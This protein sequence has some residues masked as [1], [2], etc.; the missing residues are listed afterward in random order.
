MLNH[1]LTA[2][3]IALIVAIILWFFVMNDQNPAIE[4][5][6]TVP[7]EVHNV[8]E[9]YTVRYDVDS[10]KL[11][12]KG[13]RSLF[14]AASD[15]E[16]RAFIDLSGLEE[17]KHAV[18]VQT[19]L[20]QGFELAAISTESV[21][22]EVD[23][24]IERDIRVDMAFSGTP[25]SGVTV[26]RATPERENVTVEGPRSI[27][28]AISRVV[29][30]VNLSGIDNDFTT[31]VQLIAV[32]IDGKEVGG[33]KVKPDVVKVSTS[34]VKGLYKKEVDLRP[35]LG[36]DLPAGLEI[37]SVKLDPPKVEIYGDQRL[38]DKIDSIYTEKIGLS[39]IASSAKRQVKLN[40][41]LGI[42]TTSTIVNV[43]LEY[44]AKSAE[45][46][47]AAENGEDKP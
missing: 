14:A 46:K 43:Q 3:I 44:R 35:S 31:D 7:L 12:A 32:N 23:K 15:K 16:F 34:I 8:S 42:N 36:D 45:E 5:S 47:K 17:G 1:N 25:E 33:V 22:V 40:L 13:P 21:I 24:I 19:I 6:F 28:D 27:V 30:Y 41:P 11:K 37:T 29:G 38:V 2:K 4:S 26:G 9:G 39:D 20:P 10:V 18:K